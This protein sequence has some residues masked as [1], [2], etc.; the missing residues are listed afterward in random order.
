MDG[1]KLFA[2]NA[3]CS[4]HAQLEVLHHTVKIFLDTVGLNFGLSASRRKVGDVMLHDD[5]WIEHW[6]LME[7]TTLFMKSYSLFCYLAIQTSLN[8]TADIDITL[9][10]RRLRKSWNG[11]S[12]FVLIN[13]LTQW[14][15]LRND[16]PRHALIREIWLIT[17]NLIWSTNS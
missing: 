6:N 9:D 10:W 5:S 7:W 16:S 15:N 1:L 12:A 14:K 8:N 4:L 2:K 17:I 11:L 3:W 13:K